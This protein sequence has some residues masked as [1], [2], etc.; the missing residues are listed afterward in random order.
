M[1]EHRAVRPMEEDNFVQNVKTGKKIHMVRNGGSY[2]VE[3]N[4][5]ARNLDF[6]G[7]AAL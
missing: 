7:L 2:V 6:P 4:Y 3:V 1:E 5:V